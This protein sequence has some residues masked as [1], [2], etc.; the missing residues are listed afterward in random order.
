[1]QP[2]AV[3]DETFPPTSIT[4]FDDFLSAEVGTNGSD[5]RVTF[6]VAATYSASINVADHAMDGYVVSCRIVPE[7]GLPFCRDFEG[8]DYDIRPFSGSRS[9][10]ESSQRRFHATGAIDTITFRIP[11]SAIGARAGSQRSRSQEK[12]QCGHHAESTQHLTRAHHARPFQ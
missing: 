11:Q 4:L 2:T 7:T 1:M 6:H 5:V 3:P 10:V 8:R 9:V 12:E